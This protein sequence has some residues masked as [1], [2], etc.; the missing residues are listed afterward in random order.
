MGD[1]HSLLTSYSHWSEKEWMRYSNTW[2]N[3]G[4]GWISDSWHLLL[5]ATSLLTRPKSL[6]RGKAIEDGVNKDPAHAS[7]WLQYSCAFW[8][9]S[10][11]WSV[12]CAFSHDKGICLWKS[13]LFSKTEDSST[14]PKHTHFIH[15]RPWDMMCKA[16]SCPPLKVG[17]LSNSMSPAMTLRPDSPSLSAKLLRIAR[18]GLS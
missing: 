15:L 14:R 7:G 11:M 8:N 6:I 4:V 5:S 12:H 13:N 2:V 3:Q 17:V 16:P 18:V 10:L 9:I 1:V